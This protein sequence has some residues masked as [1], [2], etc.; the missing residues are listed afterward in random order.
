MAAYALHKPLHRL[1]VVSFANMALSIDWAASWSGMSEHI[2]PRD[3]S[4]SMWYTIEQCKGSSHPLQYSQPALSLPTCPS[5]RTTPTT[6]F[7]RL[8]TRVL[9]GGTRPGSRLP[10]WPS[11]S[12][13]LGHN[14]S[15]RSPRS[16]SRTNRTAQNCGWRVWAWEGPCL[17]ST[18]CS[19]TRAPLSHGPGQDTQPKCVHLLLA[20]FTQLILFAQG[21]IPGVNSSAITLAA[22]CA[23]LALATSSSGS[24]VVNHPAWF[25]AGAAA[26]FVMY[27]FRD[28]LG[29]AGGLVYGLFLMSIFPRMLQE[30]AFRGGA[31]V[32]FLSWVVTTLL[33]LA[34]VR[35]FV[36]EP[37]GR[38]TAN[39]LVSRYGP[40]RMLLYLVESICERERICKRP[41]E[42]EQA[43]ANASKAS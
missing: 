35:V 31:L 24:R 22:L 1:L 32:Y 41:V 42:Y 25:S 10:F 28:W 7:G 13:P 17:P 12:L 9:E 2:N 26:C 19:P 14:T 30:S 18:R 34:D 21:P 3:N 5:L 16:V 33:I 37:S 38:L 27:Y 11:L 8:S 40:R 23:G 4:L 39:C 43:G 15:T 6:L 20:L 29:H 36:H